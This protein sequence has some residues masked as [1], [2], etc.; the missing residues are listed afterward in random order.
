[1]LVATLLY[2][3]LAGI[4]FVVVGALVPCFAC[5]VWLIF[6]LPVVPIV[7]YGWQAFQGQYVNI[8]WLTDF[9][10]KNALL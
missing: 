4:V 6:F 2:E 7:Y 1:L 8:P 10:K 5:G 3:I 9:L